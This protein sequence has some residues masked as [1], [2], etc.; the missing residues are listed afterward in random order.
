MKNFF[1]GISVSQIIAGALAAVTSFL[2]SIKI[3]IGGSVIGVAVGSIVSAV[4]SQIYQN[5]I[6]ESGKKLQDGTSDDVNETRDAFDAEDRTRVISAAANSH[7]QQN[8][9]VAPQRSSAMTTLHLDGTSASLA[10]LA[11]KDNA[12]PENRGKEQT[13]TMAVLSDETLATENA[14]P[15]ATSASHLDDTKTMALTALKERQ[16]ADVVKP[17]GTAHAVKRVHGAG[18]S[19]QDRNKRIAI[20]VAVVSA[21]LAVGITAAVISLVTKGQGTDNVV[22][23]LVT[24]SSTEPSQPRSNDSKQVPQRE[25]KDDGSDNQQNGGNNQNGAGTSTDSG[26]SADS[27]SSNGS[28]TVPNSGTPG[29]NN[30]S[31]T[32]N[33]SSKTPGTSKNTDSGT[34][35]SGSGTTGVPGNG[36]TDGS[37]VNGTGGDG[38]SSTNSSNSGTSDKNSTSTNRPSS[39][40]SGSISNGSAVK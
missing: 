27:G 32:G 31:E 13:K 23:D 29:G 26:S 20:I 36:G 2:L 39:T 15:N 21:L 22:R 10:A 34:S 19:H 8:T 37:S 11:K 5:I 30:S 12:E 14:K 38:T 6:K 17:S 35:G 4:A 9:Q 25:R 16:N 7:P 3:G 24:N 28:G 33:G 1:K 18:T 40:Q